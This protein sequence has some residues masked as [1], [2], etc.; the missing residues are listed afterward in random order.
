[1]I[2]AKRAV[3]VGHIVTNESELGKHGPQG[4]ARNRLGSDAP[5][6]E[7]RQLAEKLRAQ[8]SRLRSPIL[9]SVPSS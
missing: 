9:T 1:M 2:S 4:V 6:G 7:I 5:E 3:V 8:L